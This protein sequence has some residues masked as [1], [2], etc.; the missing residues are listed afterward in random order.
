M[1]ELSSLFFSEAIHI[2]SKVTSSDLTA[3]Y[4]TINGQQSHSSSN[5]YY[6]GRND[7]NQ[8]G[9]GYYRGDS[10]NGS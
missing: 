6:K 2:E 5:Q 8:H 3:A 1:E 10:R 7:S 9:R 4:A